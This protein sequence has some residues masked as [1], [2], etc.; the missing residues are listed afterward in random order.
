MTLHTFYLSLNLTSKVF[1][2]Q[3]LGFL[4]FGRFSQ[5]LE[6]Y[7]VRKLNLGYHRFKYI[8]A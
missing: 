7:L 2:S 5:I 8:N 6:K 4:Y 1:E 3:D